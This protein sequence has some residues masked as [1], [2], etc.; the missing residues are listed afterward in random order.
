MIKIDCR[1]CNRKRRVDVK[2]MARVAEAVIKGFGRKS[3]EVNIIFVA[4]ARIR[5]MNR[6]YLA[7]A[8]STDVISFWQDKSSGVMPGEKDFL[9]DVAV[10]TDT[11]ARNSRIFGAT[12]AE[13]TALCVIHG[14][15]HLLGF[16]DGTEKEKKVMREHENAFLQKVGGIL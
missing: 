6:E 2:K 10:S 11:A 12:F 14:V 1:N 16:R 7:C 5:R 8:D 3:A 15:L 13:E 4:D 9:G